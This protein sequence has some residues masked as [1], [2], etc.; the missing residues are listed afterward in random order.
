MGITAV[1]NQALGTW[2]ETLSRTKTVFVISDHSQSQAIKDHQRIAKFYKRQHS[3]KTAGLLLILAVHW[4]GWNI[5]QAA[6]TT[7]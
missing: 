6:S 7:Q 5:R 2:H 4:A 3:N 1:L